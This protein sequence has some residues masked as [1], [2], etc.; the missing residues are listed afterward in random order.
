[1][2]ILSGALTGRRYRIEGELPADF[3]ERFAE[4]LRT[5]AF[6]DKSSLGSGEELVGWVEIHNLLDTGFEELNS[7]LYDRYAL[8]SMRVDKKVLPA[9]LFR[10]HLD[11]RVQAWCAENQRSRCPASVRSELKELLTFEMMQKTLPR[12]SVYEVCWNVSDGWLLFHNLSERANE[13]FVKL[14][15][16]TFGYHPQPM[17]PLDMLGADASLADALLSTGGMDYLPEVTS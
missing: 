16:E 5:Y 11:K 13:R 15:F 10:A 7:W 4:S 8:F 9:K 14:F 6:R 3:R 17:V 12:V 2:G 1:M